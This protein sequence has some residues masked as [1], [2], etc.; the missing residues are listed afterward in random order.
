MTY[1]K[2]LTLS[3][4]MLICGLS[5]YAAQ[6]Q[7]TTVLDKVAKAFSK[8]GGINAEFKVRSVMNN[9]AQDEMTGKI[10]LKGEKFQLN[11][12]EIEVWFDGKTQWS[13]LSASGEV[14]VT[15]PTAQELQGINPYTFL[16]LYKNGFSSKLGSVNTF[17]GRPVWQVI[18]T[19]TDRKQ[20]IAFIILYINK[21][22]YQPV[23]LLMQQRGNQMRSE[24]TVTNYQTGLNFADRLFVYDKK[25]HPDAEIIDLR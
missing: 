11:S 3:V 7:A 6:E 24:I 9:R 14:N 22:N 25:N 23:Y 13:Y 19:A 16:Y 15:T 21:D 2:Q 20:D 12:D 17:R 18:L 5:V 8:A 1:M 4:V 10:R